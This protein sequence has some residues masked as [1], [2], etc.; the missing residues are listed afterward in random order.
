MQSP[1]IIEAS[2]ET[3][4]IDVVDRSGELPVVVDF[5]A[6][7]CQPCQ[8]LGPI[9][10]KLA[11]EYDGKF[12]LVKAETERV[13]QI[14]EQFGVQSIPAV[15]ALRDGQLV[16]MF[17]GLLP[18]PQI[19][20]W[21]DRLLPSPAEMLVVAARALE[22]TNPAAAEEHYR[23][24]MLLTPSLPAATIGLAAL[25]LTQDRTDEARALVDQLEARGFLEP[26]AQRL[27]SQLALSLHGQSAG[28]LE[29]CRTA[30][31]AEPDNLELQL[32]L[33]ESLAAAAQYE[34]ALQVALALVESGRK[35]FVEPARK[36]MVDIFHLL[37]ADSE[38]TTN[39]RR[40]LSTALY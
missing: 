16:D 24:A 29:T 10:E 34:E 35:Q 4:Q 21:L 12:L 9:L 32:K 1:W 18:E 40:R 31:A 20:A 39:Y 27:K 25:L 2:A 11:V 38:L 3:F 17:V 19:R 23:E 33:A 14:A 6:A 36:V 26:E 28:S 15:Y 37:P 30:A 8:M 5:W 7:W 22:A 13:P